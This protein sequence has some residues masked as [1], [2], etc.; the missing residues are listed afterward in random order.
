VVVLHDDTVDR[1]TNGCGPVAQH[2][3]AA[4]QA[5]DAGAWFGPQFAGERVPTFAEILT[6]YTGRVHIHTEVK[7][8]QASLVRRT[9]DLIRQHG[10]VE[11]VTITS[12]QRVRLEEMR[13]YAPELPT[14]W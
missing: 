2:T 4:L 9:A 1:T 10:M 14:G 11:Q 3:L 12:F 7:G 8:R 5:L 6:R 13:A